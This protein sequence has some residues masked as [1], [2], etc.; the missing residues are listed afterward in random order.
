MKTNNTKQLK[1]IKEA[2]NDWKAGGLTDK[3][4]LLI[5]QQI[6]YKQPKLS[7]EAIK[8]GKT[9][10]NKAKELTSEDLPIVNPITKK[11]W[12]KTCKE[13]HDVLLSMEPEFEYLNV[14]RTYDELEVLNKFKKSQKK[15]SKSFE[16]I[17]EEKYNKHIGL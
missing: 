12:T 3:T 16:D 10:I 17:Q 5:I 14:P 9:L 4:T 11:S 8:Y 2:I 7:K 1:L 15:N 13:A 6:L